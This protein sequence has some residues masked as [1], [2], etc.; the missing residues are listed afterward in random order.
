MYKVRIITCIFTSVDKGTY[1]YT[2]DTN[3][4]FFKEMLNV[5]NPTVKPKGVVIF[6]FDIE[7][8]YIYIQNAVSSSVCSQHHTVFSFLAQIHATYSKR[9]G[10]R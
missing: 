7:G 1:Y 9:Q 8:Y 2:A 10:K 4:I 3:P 6:V 5:N